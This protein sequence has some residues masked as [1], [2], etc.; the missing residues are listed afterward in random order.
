MC[1]ASFLFAPPDG[2]IPDKQPLMTWCFRLLIS[3]TALDDNNRMESIS[4][5]HHSLIKISIFSRITSG[6]GVSIVFCSPLSFWSWNISLQ[7]SIIFFQTW[8]IVSVQPFLLGIFL[9]SL[10]IPWKGSNFIFTSRNIFNSFEHQ[11]QQLS[12]KKNCWLL[13]LF[14]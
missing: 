6:K 13:S 11:K 8:V 3:F 9:T 2:G 10:C 1:I 14:A 5:V 7:E 4:A 12:R